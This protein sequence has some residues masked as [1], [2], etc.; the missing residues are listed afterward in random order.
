MLSKAGGKTYSDIILKTVEK[1]KD[2][3]R[4]KDSNN[5]N[6]ITKFGRMPDTIEDLK[7]FIEK[8]IKVL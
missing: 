6:V 7:A 8:L 5:Y 2:I 1:N 3:K 4:K